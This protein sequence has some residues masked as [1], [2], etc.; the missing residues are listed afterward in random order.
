MTSVAERQFHLVTNMSPL[1]EILLRR[2]CRIRTELRLSC[3]S[4]PLQGD[5]HSTTVAEW[6][7]RME[8]AGQK[9]NSGRCTDRVNRVDDQLIEQK[10]TSFQVFIE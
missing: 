7:K 4:D 9:K 8:S 2:M 10:F 6:G 3:Q 5:G 1:T